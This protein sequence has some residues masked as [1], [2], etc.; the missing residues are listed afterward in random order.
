MPFAGG[1]E[2]AGAPACCRDHGQGV[3][4]ILASRYFTPD[5]ITS[6]VPQPPPDQEATWGPA[7]AAYLNKMEIPKQLHGIDVFTH[8]LDYAYNPLETERELL[9][10]NRL[11]EEIDKTIKR[12]AQFKAYKQLGLVA[13]LDVNT[14]K[15][16]EVSPAKAIASARRHNN[17]N[18]PELA[19]EIAKLAKRND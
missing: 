1:A 16:I 9:Q 15:L 4:A 6:D 18:S 2:I 19:K 8:A 13:R 12:L 14:S 7:I 11:H 10:E 17:E 3:E 5:V